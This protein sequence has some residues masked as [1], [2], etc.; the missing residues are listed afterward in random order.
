VVVKLILGGTL[1]ERTLLHSSWSLGDHCGFLAGPLAFGK[2]LVT[3]ELG[4]W[5]FGFVGF[6][7]F[8]RGVM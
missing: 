5:I 2:F 7:H 6:P 4:C 8:V 1:K 3:C